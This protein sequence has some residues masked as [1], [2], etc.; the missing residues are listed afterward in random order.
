MF[1]NSL[2]NQVE[3]SLSSCKN[4][5]SR[6]IVRLVPRISEICLPYQRNC[7]VNRFRKAFAFTYIEVFP[8]RAVAEY[9]RDLIYIYILLA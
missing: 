1:T 4:K 5:K 8:Y 3:K 6:A 7:S 9:R 2:I